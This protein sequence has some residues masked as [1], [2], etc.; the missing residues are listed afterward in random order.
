M[1]NIQYALTLIG[2]FIVV[3]VILAII[4][5]TE[6]FEGTKNITEKQ[7]NEYSRLL[8]LADSQN[9]W[10]GPFTKE[11]VEN[12][13]VKAITSDD[14]KTMNRFLGLLNNEINNA[15]KRK[16]PNTVSITQFEAIIRLIQKG[17]QMGKTIPPN[18]YERL[19]NIVKTGNQAAIKNFIEMANNDFEKAG[20]K[21]KIALQEDQGMQRVVGMPGMQDMQVATPPMMQ[22]VPITY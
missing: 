2:I 3:S 14:V 4:R 20:P 22:G 19:I 1:K 16:Q 11:F 15:I 10:S 12:E 21:G 5:P 17:T 7:I 6:A 13:Y 8:T 18:G 9:V